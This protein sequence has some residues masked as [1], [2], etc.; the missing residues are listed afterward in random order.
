MVPCTMKE[1][2]NL[3]RAEKQFP[4]GTRVAGPQTPVGQ[5]RS[6]TVARD[7]KSSGGELDCGQLPNQSSTTNTGS[8]PSSSLVANP[9]AIS[10][11]M[12][13]VY[14]SGL[15]GGSRRSRRVRQGLRLD[16]LE[17][18]RSISDPVALWGCKSSHAMATRAH[19]LHHT[20]P[21]EIM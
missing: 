10:P 16:E 17:A 13:D 11:P 2:T 19:G 15:P 6:A 3:R 21:M 4:G 1:C 18:V 12:E 20:T 14:N 9:Y 7:L 5:S 8:G